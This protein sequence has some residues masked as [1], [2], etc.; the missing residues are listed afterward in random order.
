MICEITNKATDTICWVM[1][2]GT[3]DERNFV[4]DGEVSIKDFMLSVSLAILMVVFIAWWY[5]PCVWIYNNAVWKNTGSIINK[6]R[7][8]CK[9]T[10]K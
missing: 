8:K 5:I 4:P 7:F 3:D 6:K 1:S 2:Y 9:G 10:I